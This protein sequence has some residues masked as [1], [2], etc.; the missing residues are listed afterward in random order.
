M[1]PLHVGA[2]VSAVAARARRRLRRGEPGGACRCSHGHAAHTHLRRGSDCAQCP[3]GQCTRFRAVRGPL[4]EV[5]ELPRE[6]HPAPLAGPGG[7]T[8]HRR[9][10]G[11]S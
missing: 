1:I 10:A 11:G 6:R 4:A 3:P 7:G 2:T 9:A 8:P 5:V